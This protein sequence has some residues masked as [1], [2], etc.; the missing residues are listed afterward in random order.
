M[1]I[2]TT[3][4]YGDGGEMT[5]NYII[6]WDWD[7]TPWNDDIYEKFDKDWKEFFKKVM[8]LEPKFKQVLANK[9]KD[10]RIADD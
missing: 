9:Y 6:C 5:E 10:G 8:E 2:W 1:G 4:R 3:A 7:V